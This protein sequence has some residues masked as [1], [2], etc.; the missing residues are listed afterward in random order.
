MD[1]HELAS[2]KSCQQ[3]LHLTLIKKGCGLCKFANCH[4]GGPHQL[5]QLSKGRLAKQICVELTATVDP[6]CRRHQAERQHVTRERCIAGTDAC[7]LCDV[8]RCG[9]EHHNIAL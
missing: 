7:Q 4:P 2:L 6:S 9:P 5:L 1:L 3:Q 8:C